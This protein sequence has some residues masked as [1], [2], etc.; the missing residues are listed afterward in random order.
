MRLAAARPQPIPCYAEMG[1]TNPLFILR[2]ALRERGAEL[3]KGLQTSFT[4]GSGQFCTKPGL[5][6]V[7]Q[8]GMDEFLD[9][10]RSGVSCAR[11][12]WDADAV[13]RGAL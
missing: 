8:Q 7:P 1:S 9:A 2:G 3:A 11:R 12:A 13:D 4:L 5:V 10:L 6:F